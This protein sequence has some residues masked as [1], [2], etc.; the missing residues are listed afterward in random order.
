[1]E[2][3]EAKREETFLHQAVP[4][5]L[6]EGF[7]AEKIALVLSVEL[8]KVQTVIVLLEDDHTL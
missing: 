2:I 4:A 7:N 5:L 1:M 3:G 6:K 8:E